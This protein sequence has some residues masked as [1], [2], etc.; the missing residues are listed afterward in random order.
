[1][2]KLFLVSPIPPSVN[3][4]LN[5]KI[6]SRKNGR[7]FVQAYPSEETVVYKNFF[8]DYVKDQIRIQKWKTPEKGKIVFVKMTFYFDRKRKD[9]NNYLKVPFDVFSDARV[10]FDDDTALPICDRV[11][12]DKNYPRVEFEIYE[13]D[14]VGIFDN[15]EGYMEFVKKN[16]ENCKKKQESCSVLKM[17]RDNRL[18]DEI[19][20]E[21]CLKRK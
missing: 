17:A 3:N 8:T 15:K 13:S 1:M 16:C 20:G 14:F 12:I 19:E 4:Y 18:I 7:K 21:T 6:A 9:P 10:Y 11:Y 2:Q 5:Y